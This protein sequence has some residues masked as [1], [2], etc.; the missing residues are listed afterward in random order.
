[1]VVICH[2][3]QAMTT[4]AGLSGILSGLLSTLLIY[5]FYLLNPNIFLQ[6]LSP[7][8]FWIP[9]AG[10]LGLMI[11][12][13]FLAGR[14]SRTARP[15]RRVVLGGV[16]GG[17]AGTILFCF[18]GAAVAG[19]AQ[20]ISP[21]EN[22]MR[23]AIASNS[24]LYRF[25]TQTQ[26]AFLVL[27]LGGSFSGVIG[28]WL[29]SNRLRDSVEVFNKADPQMAMNAAITAVPASIVAAALSAYLYPRLSDLLGD[30]TGEFSFAGNVSTFPMGVSLLLVLL[31]H[32]ALMLVI[33]HE[34]HQAEHRCGLD[35]VKMAAY[36]SIGAAPLLILLLSLVNP[37]AF[38]N[39]LVPIALLCS[40]LISLKSLRFLRN[41]I[42]PRRASF[43]EPSTSRQ[44]REAKW[45]GTIASSPASRLVVLCIGCGL[46][47]VL[48][49]H[50]SVF[51]VLIN[52]SHALIKPPV[53]QSIPESPWILLSA[54]GLISLGVMAA[55]ILLLTIIYLFY[56]NLA[57]KYQHFIQEP[58]KIRKIDR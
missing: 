24:I 3:I 10:M 47:M 26:L 55:S 18:W 9:A 33:P 37:K 48:P 35:E 16:S 8:H 58:E 23:A 45:F 14:W 5:P 28:G 1:M 41:Q 50:I 20:W 56:V 6:K 11:L 39:P 49:L 25:I 44:K 17:L 53:S 4:Q 32:F 12:G 22:A 2:R 30:Q 43:P 7:D 34:A 27:F 13:G 40:S 21:A 51:S 54:Q 29:S 19:S 15:W 57:R 46:A 31:S 42:L 36:V 38:T 52:L